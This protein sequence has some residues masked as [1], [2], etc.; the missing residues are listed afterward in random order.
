MLRCC[1]HIGQALV[2]SL[3]VHIVNGWLLTVQPAFTVH[4]RLSITAVNKDPLTVGACWVRTAVTVLRHDHP[5]CERIA[6][7]EGLVPAVPY[8]VCSTATASRTVRISR[9]TP[10]GGTRG[11]PGGYTLTSCCPL[12]QE[13]TKK[14]S[15]S[16]PSFTYE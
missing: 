10:A 13:G 3:T 16:S 8:I 11:A 4:V 2:I 7:G 1:I 6:N 14:H 9:G 5:R 12:L 15:D